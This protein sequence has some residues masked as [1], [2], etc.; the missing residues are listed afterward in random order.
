M[1]NNEVRRDPNTRC[2]GENDSS[3]AL[4]LRSQA[5]AGD[6]IPSPEEPLG[7]WQIRDDAQ[8]LFDEL[9]NSCWGLRAT[10]TQLE[11]RSAA[12]LTGS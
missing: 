6:N 12:A 7:L 8:Q 4:L 3:G 2:P 10:A 5:V 1:Q 9:C 11:A